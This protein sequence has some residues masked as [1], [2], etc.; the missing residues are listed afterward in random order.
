M[1][2]GASTLVVSRL[3]YSAIN[4]FTIA[5][6]IIIAM[7]GFS[8]AL[9]TPL[10]QIFTRMFKMSEFSILSNSM[11]DITKIISFFSI[12]TFVIFIYFA[13]YFFKLYL[14]KGFSSEVVSI[15]LSLA[16]I[17]LVRLYG[18]PFFLVLVATGD[19]TRT[20]KYSFL[21]GFVNFVFC[22]I[23]V[24]AF[25]VIGVSYSLALSTLLVFAIYSLKFINQIMIFKIEKFKLLVLFLFIPMLIIFSGFTDSL[26]PKMSLLT[27]SLLTLIALHVNIFTRIKK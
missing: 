6:N 8:S 5:S 13:E 1:I 7:I 21:D 18:I 15:F 23:F 4:N 22:M 9:L 17:H 11:F 24:K 16:A 27:L 20:V 14:G 12:L 19:H 10:L 2:T 25:G 26:V 3:D